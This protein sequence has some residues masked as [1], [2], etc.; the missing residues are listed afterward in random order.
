MPI[1]VVGGGIVGLASALALRARGHDVTVLE[2]EADLGAHQT[3]RNSGVIH[4]GL[5]YRPG[6]LK[7]ETCRAGRERMYT[8][9]AE[10]GIPHRRT[11]K[12]VVATT[13]AELP[14]LETLLERGR[15]NGL[16]GVRR[17]D[18]GE[19][20]ELEPHAT[21]IAALWVPQTGIVDYVEVLRAM[22]RLLER[23]GVPVCLGRTVHAVRHESDALILDTSAETLRARFLVNCAGLQ[24]DRMAVACGVRPVVRIVPFR[25]EYYLLRPQRAGLVRNPIYP[26]PDPAFPFLGVHFTPRIDGRVEAGPN[27]V[28]AW[29]RHGYRTP[30]LSLRDA[31]AT[32]GWPGFWPM[33]RRHWRTGL[34]E[35]RRAWSVD[36]FVRSLQAL[37]PDV[38]RADVVRAGCG[39][40]AQAVGRDGALVDDFLVID[41]RRELHVLNAPSPAATASLAIGELVADRTLAH[42]AWR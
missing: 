27:A 28:L 11:G 22:R 26:V 39:I 25:G 37:V 33:A 13:P 20:R 16:D 38:T 36:R 4:S 17:L 32:L 14:R 24:S 9:C 31:T 21:G 5:Y 34:A 30:S 6:S 29:D 18:T 8:F 10:H 3:G 40:R 19:L 12:A 7:A 35:Q 41:G 1:A 23:N 42:P 2:A 15:L